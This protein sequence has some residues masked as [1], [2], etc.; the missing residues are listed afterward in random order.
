M[1]D[2]INKKT[3]EY[4]KTYFAS[5]E[6]APAEDLKKQI[7]FAINNPIIQVVLESVEGFVIIL[8]EHRQ[9]LAGNR[10]ILD[11]LG[12]EESKK[13]TGMRPGELLNCIHAEEG[14]GRCGTSRYCNTC[15]AVISILSCQATSQSVKGECNMVMYKNNRLENI[16][17]Q[18]HVTP[19][20][21]NDC[22]F[23]IFVLQDIS[24]IKR[25]EV[26]EQVFFHD[27]NNILTGL[28]GWTQMLKNTDPV[29][30]ANKIIELSDYLK[31]EFNYQ[32]N[33]YLAEKG[34]LNIKNTCVD[35]GHI[36]NRLETLFGNNKF[37]KNKHIV[38]HNNTGNISFATETTLI[39]RVLINMIKNALE[40]TEKDGTVKVYAKKDGEHLVFSVHNKGTIPEDIALNIF[41]RS[42]STKEG[43][44]RGMGTYSMKLFGENYLGGKVTFTSTEKEGTTFSISL[45]LYIEP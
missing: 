11:M 32:Y 39:M 6:R 31:Q 13:I 26:L 2:H 4:I 5:P 41:K 35:T 9:I 18:V 40:A 37:K 23:L 25:R 36:F 14:P 38:F 30:A 16:E 15:G 27:I 10:E 33:L 19:V 22:K 29:K 1:T 3:D 7:D 8:N 42:F 43:K 45:P 34:E 21:I 24:S 17:F 28:I 44:G 12:T 20:N